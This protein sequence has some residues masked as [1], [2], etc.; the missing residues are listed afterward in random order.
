MGAYRR[1]AGGI[2]WSSGEDV[3]AVWNRYSLEHFAMYVA[4]E[5]IFAG[6]PKEQEILAGHIG[7]AFT[8]IAKE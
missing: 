1:H 4:L 3:D 5:R 7:E 2:W 8:A 6:R